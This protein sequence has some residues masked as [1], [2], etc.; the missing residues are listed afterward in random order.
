MDDLL[1]HFAAVRPGRGEENCSCCRATGEHDDRSECDRCDGSGRMHRGD[2]AALPWCPGRESDQPAPQR[3]R[4]W[5]E[6]RTAVRRD[7]FHGEGPWYHGTPEDL[8]PGAVIQPGDVVGKQHMGRGSDSTRTWVTNDAWK[9]ASYGT[10]VYEVDPSVRPKSMYARHHEHYLPDGGTATVLRQVPYQE[11]TELSPEYQ[12]GAR[13]MEKQIRQQRRQ[14][15]E[16]GVEDYGIRHRPME[17]GAPVHDL[18]GESPDADFDSTSYMATDY[19]EHPGYYSDT[20]SNS[21]GAARNV[22]PQTSP[23]PAM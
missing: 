20:G 1:A 12:R 16:A 6:P 17:H 7:P 3:R 19:L 10:N 13:A 4:H 8:E 2:D 18:T 5:R 14:Q 23:R 15:H 11:A 21:R 9:A 22:I